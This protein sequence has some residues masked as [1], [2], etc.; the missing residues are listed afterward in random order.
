LGLWRTLPPSLRETFS[1]GPLLLSRRRQRRRS[2]RA[3]HLRSGF[4]RKKGEG[5]GWKKVLTRENDVTKKR[6]RERET[7]LLK[8][9]ENSNGKRSF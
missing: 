9:I 7:P 2:R 5:K 4:E 3:A 8:E 1:G 6:E